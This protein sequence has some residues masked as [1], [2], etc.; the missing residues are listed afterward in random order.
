MW[1]GYDT[2]NGKRSIPK[3]NSQFKG[4]RDNW[5]RGWPSHNKAILI[6]QPT[7]VIFQWT[8]GQHDGHIVVWWRT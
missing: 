4:M 8:S 7:L 3:T 2:Q 5:L 1:R 6:D